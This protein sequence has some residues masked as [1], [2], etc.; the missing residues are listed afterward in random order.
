MLFRSNYVLKF[1]ATQGN[2]GTEFLKNLYNKQEQG[3]FDPKEIRVLESFETTYAIEGIDYVISIF[4]TSKVSM[5]N[6]AGKTG[7]LADPE[8]FMND[9]TMAGVDFAVPM[10]RA[11]DR[12]DL[13]SANKSARSLT[14][15]C[16]LTD[17]QAIKLAQTYQTG[18]DRKS[19]RLNSSHIPLSRMPSSA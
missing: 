2:F 11:L 5:S 10:F 1:Q 6:I 18:S 4:V 9:I 7:E 3:N 13:F 12:G 15:F 8:E 14:L 16:G 17:D 19:T